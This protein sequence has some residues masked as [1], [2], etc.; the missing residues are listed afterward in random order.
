MPQTLFFERLETALVVTVI[1]VLVWLYAEGENVQTYTNQRVQVEFIPPPGQ[2]LAIEPARPIEVLLNLKASAGEMSRFDSILR[3][4][5][6]TIPIEIGEEQNGSVVV[7]RE[8]FA[9]TP[10]GAM[11]LNITS[12]SPEYVTVGV[13]P[14]VTRQLRVVPSSAPVQFAKPPTIEPAVVDVTLRESLAQ[15]AEGLTVTARLPDQPDAYASFEVNTPESLEAPLVLPEP[16]V[17]R[18][19]RMEPRT[20]EVTFTIRKL[21][22]SY[23]PDFITI[24][25][26]LDP[27]MMRDYD[28]E[29]TDLV[30]REITLTGPSDAIERIRRGE[31][32]VEALLR[33]TNE[34]L[35]RGVEALQPSISA[36]PGVTPANP[37]PPVGVRI[38]RKPPR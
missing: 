28:I 2:D 9:T 16:L 32:R 15:A 5:D 34:Q 22:D 3:A 20:A 21:T 23:R 7:I 33:P 1:S 11:G 30:L 25:V 13:E 31:E 38:V 24:R 36:P 29:P 27:L 4:R 17:D 12:T 10:L 37:P 26:V 14:M 8:A 18:R 19:T 6:G 35:E